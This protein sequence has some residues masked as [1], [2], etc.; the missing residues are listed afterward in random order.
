[1]PESWL[2]SNRYVGPKE[3][4]QG[5]FPNGNS[6]ANMDEL[7]GWH[8]RLGAASLT[9][10]TAF[11]SNYPSIWRTLT[12]M[13]DLFVRRMNQNGYERQF[14]P[15][16]SKIDPSRRGVINEAANRFLSTSIERK[17]ALGK[18]TVADMNASIVA[19][20]AYVQGKDPETD[21][22]RASKAEHDEV[23]ELARRLRHWF[24]LSVTDWKSVVTAPYFRG[25][26]RISHCTGDFALPDG[27][28]EIKSGERMFRSVDYRQL[29]IYLALHYGHTGILFKNLMLVNPRIG[30]SIQMSSASLSEEIS[31]V[32]VT[33]LCNSLLDSFAA[34]L[35]SL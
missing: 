22:G 20:A 31:G 2:G 8:G 26:G 21:F 14:T 7:S 25:H 18:L 28:V 24:S 16:K 19:A 15:L 1:M 23:V 11:S 33:E 29:L 10:E 30:V 34:E 32:S 35:V 27:I 6:Y 3:Y 17:I 4:G 13:M 12:P 5:V 9:S